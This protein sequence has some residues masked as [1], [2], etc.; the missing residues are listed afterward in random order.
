VVEHGGELVAHAVACPHWLGPL[1]EAPVEDGRIV[2][3][4]H[5]Y[6][7]DVLTGVECT[8]KGLKL[9]KPPRVEVDAARDVVRLVRG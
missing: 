7:F 3:P 8:G 5:G 2:C 6:T 9:R 4:W 1:D